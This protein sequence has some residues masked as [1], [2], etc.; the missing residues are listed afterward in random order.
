[1]M[2]FIVS[3]SNEFIN[4]LVR[5]IT[6][7]LFTEDQIKSIT[8]GAIGKHFADLFPAT[9]D[10]QE[11]K[12]RVEAAQ[13]H[14][15]AA[16]SIIL[17]MHENLESQNKS[18]DALLNEIEKKKKLAEHY[19]ILAKTN[20]KEF[21]AFRKEME[22]SLRNELEEQAA[23]GRRIRQVSSAMIWL[24]TLVIG[25]ALGHYFENIIGLIS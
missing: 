12:D 4:A 2:P 25:A 7:R 5:I 24:I 1:M 21:S 15:S 8:S 22:E 13:K 20:Q 23:K 10:E 14:I 17:E 3:F 9:K 18:L 16:N 6:G 19:S 11:A